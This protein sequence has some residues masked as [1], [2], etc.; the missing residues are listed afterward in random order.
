MPPCLSTWSM[1]RICKKRMP[2]IALV[3]NTCPLLPTVSTTMDATTTM[4]SR[5]EKNENVIPFFACIVLEYKFQMK[6]LPLNGIVKFI[7]L[8]F[9]FKNFSRNFENS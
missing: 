3:A 7:D 5:R 1:R 9:P 6:L 8:I 4:R 2:R